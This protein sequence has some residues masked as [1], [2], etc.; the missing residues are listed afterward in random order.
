M[1]TVLRHLAVAPEQLDAMRGKVR[2]FALVEA[3]DARMA[4]AF[5][6]ALLRQ[7]AA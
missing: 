4:S 6:K 5:A 2:A 7:V 1:E 3:D